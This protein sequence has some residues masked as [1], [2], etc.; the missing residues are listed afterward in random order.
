MPNQLV[1]KDALPI[2]TFAR[3]DSGVTFESADEAT[4]KL[5]YELWLQRG[6]PEGSPEEDWYRAKDLLRAGEAVLTPSSSR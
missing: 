2:Q 3:V 4:A 6:Q 1:R 5:A